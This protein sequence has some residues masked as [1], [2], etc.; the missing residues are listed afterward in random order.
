MEYLPPLLF[1]DEAAAALR[2]SVATLRRIRKRGEISTRL[3]S[4]RWRYTHADLVEYQ[5]NQKVGACVE[6][7]GPVRSQATGLPGDQNRRTGMRLGTTMT[8]VSE[9]RVAHHLAQAIFGKPK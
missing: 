1:E 9:A 3:I 7:A 6:R 4:G 5:E 8:A 2:V